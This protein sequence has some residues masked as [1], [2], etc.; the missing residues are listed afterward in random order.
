MVVRA[1]VRRA[2]IAI[3]A[4][5]GS[6][7]SLVIGW[8]DLGGGCRG[9]CE[10]GP[11]PPDAAIDAPTQDAPP[12]G[13]EAGA[14]CTTHHD[15]CDDFD[16]SADFPNL[17]R[18]TTL[19]KSGG[20]TA[21]LVTDDVRSPPRSFRAAAGGADEGT[22]TLV[23]SLAGPLKRLTC[24]FDVKP[25]PNAGKGNVFSIATVDLHPLATSS[26]EDYNIVFGTTTADHT[27]T[28]FWQPRGSTYDGTG[29]DSFAK[30]VA[31]VWQKLRFELVIGPPATLTIYYND[32]PALGTVT[33]S[34]LPQEHDVVQI[35]LGAMSDPGQPGGQVT[36][37]NV[38][39]D[40]AR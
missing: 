34:K 21:E 14:D 7:C 16:E 20:A 39:C 11:P 15:L 28:E 12:G 38:V 5:S 2:L 31:G 19:E 24:E 36:F 26:I 40:G 6:A 9:P 22:A 17:T 23:K 18:W 25:T 29:Y 13:P 3:L 30:P 8:N 27:V 4:M 37:D 32:A 10:G 33:L 35:K 1:S